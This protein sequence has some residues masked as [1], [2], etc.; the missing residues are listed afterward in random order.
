MLSKYIGDEDFYKR[1]LRVAL[2]CAL[3]QLLLS[4]RSIIASIMVSSIGMVTAVGNATNV[5]NLHNYMLWG[6]EA[7]AA[8]FGAQFFGAKQYKN[9]AKTQGVFIVLSLLHTFLWIAIVF[10]FG[11]QLLLFYLNDLTIL[12]HSY[13]YLRYV[14]I[15]LIFLCI[16][17]SIKCM[18]QSM[19]L[20][21]VTFIESA[22]YVALNILNNYL[23]IF[24]FKQGVAGAGMAALLTEILC[25]TGMIVYTLFRKPVFYLGLKE[26][27]SFD[28]G[29]IK[30][31]II[32]IMPIAFNE[33]LFGFGQS[34]FNKA[35]GMLGSGSMEVIYIGSEIFS[36][37]L[38]IVWG[39]GEAVSILVGTQLGRGRIEQAKEESKYHL[40]LSFVV[41][42]LLWLF[43]VLLSPVF[44]RLYNI[45]DPETKIL[46]TRLL[47]VYGFKA[48][49]RIFTYVMF[50]TLK[51]GGDS[52][53]YNLLDSGIMYTVGIPIAFAG[54]Y[55]GVKDIVFLVLLCQ[56]EQVVRF[57]L[58][59]KRYNSYKWANNLTN[60]VN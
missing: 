40:G 3:S 59:L 36:L 21:R 29:F 57:F 44:L 50:C 18:F 5:L 37:A 46:C 49:L 56:I 34:L 6:I 10:L 7:G 47:Q 27:F 33:I 32:K 58:T 43:M 1:V 53:V 60:L 52:A 26:M 9:M 38:F 16:T 4:C 22:V 41:G 54:V 11:R 19:H 8:L 20:T 13:I 42:L 17:L 14:F 25:C 55:F 30:P 2:P 15:S 24:V 28:F 48:F 51:A 39:Y 12:E 45:S 23:F 35:Y 31:F